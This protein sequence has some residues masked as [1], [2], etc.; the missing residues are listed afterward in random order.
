M[1]DWDMIAKSISEAGK[2]F[3][4][5]LE[6]RNRMKEEDYYRKAQEQRAIQLEQIQFERNRAAEM[7][8]RQKLMKED[9]EIRQAF[10][11]TKRHNDADLLNFANSPDLVKHVDNLETNYMAYKDP[12][13]KKEIDG[14][15]KL[16][17][18]LNSGALESELDDEMKTALDKLPAPMRAP[19]G[20]LIASNYKQKL[21]NQLAYEQIENLKWLRNKKTA[22]DAMARFS[23]EQINKLRGDKDELYKSISTLENLDK[24]VLGRQKATELGIDPMVDPKTSPIWNEVVQNP[25]NKNSSLMQSY[26][27][28]WRVIAGL[29]GSLFLL[30]QKLYQYDPMGTDPV[31]YMKELAIAEKKARGIV[32]VPEVYEEDIPAPPP[33]QPPG[34]AHKLFVDTVYEKGAKPLFLK[35]KESFQHAGE[36]EKFTHDM[37]KTYGDKIKPN[38]VT[39]LTDE[40][41]LL[42]AG[43][44]TIGTIFYDPHKK[45]LVKVVADPYDPTKIAL[46]PIAPIVK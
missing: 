38:D 6:N 32:D 25:K 33:P 23:I 16:M 35:I 19:L 8:D 15:G 3:A 18:A 41:G 39:M 28:T 13:V 46:E 12:E 24:F 31:R 21:A 1:A 11:D 4:L 7:A 17:K 20:T 44:E 5:G 34:A 14:L 29:K 26:E 45:M 9:A 42:W 36:F 27:A 43:R 2:T 22:D 10:E 37:K 30:D 40:Q